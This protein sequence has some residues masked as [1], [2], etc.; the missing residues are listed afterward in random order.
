M[1][2]CRERHHH[3]HKSPVRSSNDYYSYMGPFPGYFKCTLITLVIL[4]AAIF[5]LFLGLLLALYFSQDQLNATSN[6]TVSMHVE[7]VQ[8]KNDI[9]TALQDFQRRYPV[10]QP[11]IT[12]DQLLDIISSTQL[13]MKRAVILSEQAKQ[14]MDQFEENNVLEHVTKIAQSVDTITGHLENIN[15]GFNK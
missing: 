2:I 5:L 3:S 4:N 13:L 8:M 14:A 12:V 6:A 11:K 9:Q 7:T 10:D 15:L 1:N